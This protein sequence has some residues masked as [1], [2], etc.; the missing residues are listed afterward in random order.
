MIFYRVKPSADNTKRKILSKNGKIKIDG[1]LIG[2]ELY[3]PSEYKRLANNPNDFEKVSV[4][5]A[6]YFFGARFEM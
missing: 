4:N 1:I 6:Y 2:N 5:K 3:T